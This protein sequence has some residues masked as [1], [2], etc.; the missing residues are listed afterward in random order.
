M[1][2]Y[3]EQSFQYRKLRIIRKDYLDLLT[4]MGK[5][6]NVKREV[7]WQQTANSYELIFQKKSPTGKEQ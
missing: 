7:E 6:D 5:A 4:R 1:S 2:N 3:T